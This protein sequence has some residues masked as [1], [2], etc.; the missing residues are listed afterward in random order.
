MT[1]ASLHVQLHAT[2]N[3]IMK[4]PGGKYLARFLIHCKK[5][6]IFRARFLLLAKRCARNVKFLAQFL[7]VLQ[8]SCKKGNIF[9]AAQNVQALA[10]YYSLGHDIF[11]SFSRSTV[12]TECNSSQ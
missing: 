11:K 6:Y 12:N 10:R 5:T 4:L 3:N 2:I 8:V 1:Q 7:Q 9:N